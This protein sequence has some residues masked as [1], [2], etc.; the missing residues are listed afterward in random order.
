MLSTDSTVVSLR[1]IRAS[2][3]PCAASMSDLNVFFYCVASIDR[4]TNLHRWFEKRRT[5][6]EG[7]GSTLEFQLARL[8][9]LRFLKV[10]STTVTLYVGGRFWSVRLVLHQVPVGAGGG[11][12]PAV[13]LMGTRKGVRLF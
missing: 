7:V 9:F 1:W 3:F 13:S 10:G 5:A 2:L 8:R 12:A 4:P 11:E 6:L